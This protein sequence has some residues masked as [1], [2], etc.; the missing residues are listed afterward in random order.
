MCMRQIFENGFAP[1]AFVF[2]AVAD[3]TRPIVLSTIIPLCRTQGKLEQ[4]SSKYHSSIASPPPSRDPYNC[5]HG[6]MC[7]CI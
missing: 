7:C 3:N 1:E 5:R 6:P 2:R 4:D